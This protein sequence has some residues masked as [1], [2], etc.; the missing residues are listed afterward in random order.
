LWVVR[1][2]VGILLALV[3]LVPAG[4]LAYAVSL[5]S[6]T[7]ELVAEGVSIP[8]LQVPWMT[9]D[10]PTLCGICAG[11]ATLITLV[12]VWLLV[13]LSHRGRV[14]RYDRQLALLKS[15]LSECNEEIERLRGRLRQGATATPA[16]PAEGSAP[17]PTPFASDTTS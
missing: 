4:L 11:Y 10:I 17:S 3:I 5:Q 15:K 2:I 7:V 1:I 12:L 8:L 9:T 6:D 14:R 13:G 16:S